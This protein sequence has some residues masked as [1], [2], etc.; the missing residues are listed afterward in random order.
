MSQNNY[1]SQVLLEFNPD[2]RF[3]SFLIRNGLYKAVV[4]HAGKLNGRLMDLGCGSKPYKS[5]FQ[6]D[7]YIGV[8]YN[9]EGHPHDNEQIDVF[10]DGKTLPFPAEYFDSVFSTEVFE[11]V[12]NLE[13]ILT[14]VHRVMKKGGKIL[15]TCPFSIS[16]HEAPND[17]ARYTSF[18]L[19]H[20]FEKKGFKVLAFEKTGNHVL[21]IMQLRIMYI[22]M[23]IM[24]VIKNIPVVRAILRLVV[25]AG[26]NAWALLKNKLLPVR[27][28][29][30]LNN[31]I[32]CE[33]I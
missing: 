22:H 19:K 21:A 7:E 17:Y 18:A 24:P 27:T 20:L 29:L 25:Y 13:E 23:H 12:F 33:K 6:V 32:L 26:M 11:H 10:Y 15:V 1:R 3:P 8:D 16:E 2:I 14:E 31:V 4:R 9:S 28:D 30:Y 5:L